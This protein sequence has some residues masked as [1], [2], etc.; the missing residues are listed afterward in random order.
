MSEC[1]TPSRA[2]TSQTRSFATSRPI[3]R[4][5][6]TAFR[7]GCAAFAVLSPAAA[8]AA[9][10]IVNVTANPTPSDC[11]QIDPNVDT[12]TYL[13]AL[14]AAGANPGLDQIFF[15]VPGFPADQAVRVAGFG[16]RS[17]FD[18]IELDGS[19]QRGK[20]FLLPTDEP[21]IVLVGGALSFGELGAFSS[22]GSTVREVVLE[23]V[24]GSPVVAVGADDVALDG[25]WL[26]F[27]TLNGVVGA[28]SGASHGV[29]C[30]N[31]S[32]L[33]VV[34]DVLPTHIA[35]I[36]G[37]AIN[38]SGCSD[39][40]VTGT[41][42]GVAPD[43]VTPVE[44]QNGVLLQH[45]SIGITL[46]GP[47]P[48][49]ANLISGSGL[50]F[51]GNDPNGVAIGIIDASNVTIRNNLLGTDLTGQVAIRNRYGIR[52]TLVGGTLTILNN[53]ISG[54]GNPANRDTLADVGTGL[55][56]APNVTA[57]PVVIRGNRFGTNVA[58]TAA[59]PNVRDNLLLSVASSDVQVGGTLPGEGNQIAH[60]LSG[61]GIRF[62]TGPSPAVVTMLGNRIHDNLG[63]DVAASVGL[64]YGL[65]IAPLGSG[66]TPNDE[67]VFPYDTDS[68]FNDRQNFPVVTTALSNGTSTRVIGPLRSTQS[69]PFRLEFF[70]SP[71]CDPRGVG[72][73][74]RFLG[75]YEGSTSALGEPPFDTG[76]ST[77][78][79]GTHQAVSATATR[80]TGRKVTSEFSTCLVPLPEPG[81]AAALAGG[82]GLALLARTRSKPD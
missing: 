21:P 8:L 72:E 50:S 43:G 23:G 1:P 5:V 79:P 38:L 81:W 3:P 24:A 44:N 80:L 10:Y 73:G 18:P 82:A 58:G 78:F 69:T 67:A 61:S 68:G 40:G 12:C 20:Q 33:R 75:A 70:S 29:Q 47:Q 56:L 71:S 46:G 60:S 77:G 13:D 62:E 34:G 25:V 36:A 41:R 52:T 15:D 4:A 31:S 6:A 11:R 16:Q 2:S 64:N 26:G 74:E 65:G 45:Q 51:T 7:A 22:S 14:N 54:S 9:T 48:I 17:I 37:P 57:S 27:S 63:G 66:P 39:V 53:L 35:G 49:D 59:I 42:M 55:Y 30:A 32:G 28:T 76:L 19:L